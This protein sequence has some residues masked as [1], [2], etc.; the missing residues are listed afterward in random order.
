MSFN[1][2]YVGIVIFAK[3]VSALTSLVVGVMLYNKMYKGKEEA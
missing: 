1:P 3:L 2:D